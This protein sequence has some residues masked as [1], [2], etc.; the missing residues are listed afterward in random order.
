[1][2]LDQKKREKALR[3]EL[4]VVENQEKRLQKAF[5]KAKNPAWKIV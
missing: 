3:R 4:L 1:M 2:G 5:V